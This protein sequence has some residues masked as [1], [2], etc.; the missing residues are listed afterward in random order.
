MT[1]ITE[2]S[3]GALSGKVHC[4]GGVYLVE[5]QVRWAYL[6]R[7]ADFTYQAPDPQ[8]L[9]LGI[10][11][12]ALPFANPAMAYGG[13]NSGQAQLDKSGRFRF[14]LLNPNSYY[15]HQGRTLVTPH[16]HL[17]LSL[18]DGKTRN[19]TIDLGPGTP[20]RSLT[21]YPGKPYRT[22]ER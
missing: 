7:I 8:D 13:R 1:L 5:G 16:V 22:T 9:R 19:Y 11:G 4:E 12:S 17:A 18:K 3:D 6:A 2:F 15:N 10:A 21:N 14:S 20:L